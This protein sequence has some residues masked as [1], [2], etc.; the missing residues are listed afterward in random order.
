MWVVKEMP[1]PHR[2]KIKSMPTPP[3][4]T[5]PASLVE[6]LG[7]LPHPEGGF[8]RETYRS[9]ESI[10]EAGLP[11][12][13]QG[14]RS[15]STAI[16]FLLGPGDFSAFHRIRSD[17]T[18]HYYTGSCGLHIHV[19]CH[20]GNYRLIRLGPRSAAGET[21]QATVPAGAWFASEPADPAGFALV[22]CTVAPGFDFRDFEM[23]EAGPLAAAHP[24]L[25]ELVH[26]RC[27]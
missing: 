3:V 24:G 8:Y 10:P 21:F 18:W 6:E 7:L 12:R 26:R 23:A 5:D 1:F 14:E 15:L 4:I 13:F 25:A 2:G 16:Y 20:D 17:E 22:G 11:A 27:R 19:I 9:S